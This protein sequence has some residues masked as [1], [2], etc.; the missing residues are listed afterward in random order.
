MVRKRR[1]VKEF[2]YPVE[3]KPFEAIAH[4][5]KPKPFIL[6]F[7]AAMGLQL[8]TGLVIDFLSPFIGISLVRSV[9]Q[10]VGIF[11]TI[12]FAVYIS[13]IVINKEFRAL[14]EPINY[15]EMVFYVALI[16]FGLNTSFPNL[17]PFLGPITPFHCTLLTY[18]WLV[19]SVLGGG[20]VI[21]GLASFYYLIERTRHRNHPQPGKIKKKVKKE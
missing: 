17:I 6:L 9:H 8:I 20:G 3:T 14:R 5:F 15:I 19:V 11:F 10:Y 18:G 2:N 12:M 4:M 21:Q 1:D 16:L 13:I 7:H